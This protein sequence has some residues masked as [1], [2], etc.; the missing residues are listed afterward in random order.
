[1]NNIQRIRATRKK[2]MLERAKLNELID[3]KLITDLAY[4]RLLRNMAQHNRKYVA[5]KTGR[6]Y[7]VGEIKGIW[8]DDKT[9]D[10]CFKIIKKGAPTLYRQVHEV[11]AIGFEEVAEFLKVPR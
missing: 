6:R 2:D 11:E 9:N 1:M 7:L 4:K 10:V 5:Y 8:G 3:D